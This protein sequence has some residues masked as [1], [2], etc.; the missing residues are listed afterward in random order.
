MFSRKNT[1]K[2]LFI[3]VIISGL[4]GVI[5]YKNI[6]TVRSENKVKTDYWASSKSPGANVYGA[7]NTSSSVLAVLNKLGVPFYVHKCDKQW[8][9]ITLMNGMRGF[10]K[11]IYVSRQITS[12]VKEKLDVY[13]LPDG[14]RILAT[15]YPN[16]IVQNLH[17]NNGW[18]FINK[19]ELRGY[20]RC[21]QLIG[22]HEPMKTVSV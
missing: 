5:A 11:P 6:G 12:V 9:E 4:I 1:K 18:C 7:A 3:G 19:S 13:N 8:C 21:D 10:I 20:V 16:V 2:I 14:K 15:L 22:G 17:R